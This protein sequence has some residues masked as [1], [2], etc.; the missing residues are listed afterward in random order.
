ML[1]AGFFLDFE[2]VVRFFLLFVC[3]LVL[4]FFLLVTCFLV[5]L[6]APMFVWSGA[7]WV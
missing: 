4:D 6:G 1:V 7:V 2:L 5:V 3:F